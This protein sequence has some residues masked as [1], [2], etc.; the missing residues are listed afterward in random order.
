[1]TIAYQASRDDAEYRRLFRVNAPALPHVIRP[2]ETGLFVRR[3][4]PDH[5]GQRPSAQF[6]A[7][8]GR[9][10]LIPLFAKD[11]DYPET[12]EAQAE[13]AAAERNFRQ[14][15][16]RGHRCI[17]LADALIRRGENDA[18]LV[19]VTRSD[20]RP[21]VLAGL[22]NAWRSP[23][24]QCI[25]SFTLLTLPAEDR[26]GEQRIVF[27]RDGWIDDWVH[28]AVEEAANCLRPYDIQKLV[29]TEVAHI[30]LR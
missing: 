19:Q 22:W 12:F 21:L 17:V 29:R 16:K 1:M 27:L 13:T 3:P 14:A 23:E 26:P 11:S 30:P 8:L 5:A 28:C 10:G 9:W 25:E 18:R 7:A 20:K 15:W 24:G 4:R 2:N 6:E